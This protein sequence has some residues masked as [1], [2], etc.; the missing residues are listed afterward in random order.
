[1]EKI[2]LLDVNV[3]E[4]IRNAMPIATSE[5]NGLMSS[6]YLS[7][8]GSFA[9]DMKSYSGDINELH[10]VLKDGLSTIA[11]TVASTNRPYPNDTGGVIINVN[12]ISKFSMRLIYQQYISIT[13]GNKVKTRTGV[14]SGS[15]YIFS[16]WE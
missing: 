7:E 9:T 14:Y 11:C 16:E 1:M 6:E 5:K 15:E 3:I 13:Q 12:R 4:V 10:T 8:D 2:K